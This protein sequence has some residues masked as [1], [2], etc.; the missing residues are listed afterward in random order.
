MLKESMLG[1]YIAVEFAFLVHIF[2]SFTGS[3]IRLARSQADAFSIIRPEPVDGP[4]RQ[5]FTK[6][7]GFI[8]LILLSF[9]F[10]NNCICIRF[11]LPAENE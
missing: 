8:I 5:I 3:L 9:V 11:T 6:C 2:K 7:Y 1:C 4:S 10:I